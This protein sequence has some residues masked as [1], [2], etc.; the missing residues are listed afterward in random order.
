MAGVATLVTTTL[1]A[2]SDAVS[3]LYNGDG[4]EF[5]GSSSTATTFSVTPAPLTITANNATMVY[6]GALPALHGQFQRVRQWRHVGQSDH[7]TKPDHDSDVGQ[8]VGSYVINV[9][10]ASIRT[11]LSVT[12][13]G[14]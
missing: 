2:G 13:Q 3:A 11:T 12:W 8:P 10:G 4:V 5:Y 7:A 6:G 1:P 9:S 14:R